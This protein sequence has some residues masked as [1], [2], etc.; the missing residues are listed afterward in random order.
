MTEMKQ[1][2]NTTT[3]IGTPKEKMKTT[4]KEGEMTTIRKF[5]PNRLPVDTLHA[6]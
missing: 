3:T 4:L 2:M 5:S 6:V 1:M